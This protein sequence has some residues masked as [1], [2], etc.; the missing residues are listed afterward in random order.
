MRILVFGG[1]GFV[2]LNIAS[3][4]L[5][6]G[7]KVTLFDRGGLPPAAEK[8]FAQYA[9]RLT[10]IQADIT[11]RQAVEAVIAAGHQAIVLGAASAI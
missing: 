10:P 6:R 7:H 8:D 1:T 2:G 4:L 11:D 3:A 5:A 9:D